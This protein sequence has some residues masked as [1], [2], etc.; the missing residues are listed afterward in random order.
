MTG[1]KVTSGVNNGDNAEITVEPVKGGDAITL[2]ADK[3]LISTGRR[4]FTENL[5]AE[6]VGL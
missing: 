4:P 2:K 5:N 6:K 1:H 3:V